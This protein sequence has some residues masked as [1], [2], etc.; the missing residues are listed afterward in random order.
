MFSCVIMCYISSD[1]LTG[2][3]NTIVCHKVIVYLLSDLL[4]LT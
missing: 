3:D 2:Y 1:H 4:I